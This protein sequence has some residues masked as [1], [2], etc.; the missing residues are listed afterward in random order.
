MAGKGGQEGWRSGFRF[1]FRHCCTVVDGAASHTLNIQ[2][3]SSHPRRA[4][5]SF[6]SLKAVDR[7]LVSR[8]NSPAAGYIAVIVTSMKVLRNSARLLYTSGDPRFRIYVRVERRRAFFS[9]EIRRL[10]YIAG[11]GG[12][13]T[14]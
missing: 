3:L 9:R 4:Q 5:P 7:R 13:Y 12:L 14:A 11:G 1:I 8:R 10:G 2:L 6:S